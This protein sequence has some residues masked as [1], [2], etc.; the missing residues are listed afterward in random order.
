MATPT[1]V[2]SAL[3]QVHASKATRELKHFDSILKRT[4]KTT[5]SAT[6]KQK[7]FSKASDDTSASMRRTTKSADGLNTGLINVNQ[8][9]VSMRN[10]AGLV[11]WPAFI[12]GAGYATQGVN[13]LAAGTG[14]LA[15]SL[16]SLVGVTA[17]AVSAYGALGQAAGVV[18]LA[19]VNDLGTAVGGLNEKLDESSTEFKQLSPEARSL[20][21]R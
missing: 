19:G 11:K 10:A 18:A 20:R 2:L 9:F 6:V 13:A 15:G 16:S 12:A 21:R 17:S 8:K 3:V 1:A 4:D 5:V 7:Q 14:A